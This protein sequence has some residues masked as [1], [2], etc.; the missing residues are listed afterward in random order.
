MGSIARQLQQTLEQTPPDQHDLIA[1]LETALC[2]LHRLSTGA[3]TPCD[4][5]MAA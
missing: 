3:Q 4:Q 5:E 2:E 1:L